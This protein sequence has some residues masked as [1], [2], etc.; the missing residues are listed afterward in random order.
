MTESAGGVGGR[1]A[2]GIGPGL[3]GLAFAATWVASA[4]AP[5]EPATFLT[6]YLL[7]GLGVVLGLWLW[8]RAEGSRARRLW[9]A[10]LVTIGAGA[11][12]GGSSH[13]LGAAEEAGWLWTATMVA[14]GLAS[15]LLGLGAVW[16]F[17][18]SP[19][20]RRALGAALVLVLLVYV[21]WVPG[22][23]DFRW[24]VYDYG[25]TL[26]VLLLAAAWLGWRRREPSAPWLAAAIALSFA[27]AAIQQL[28]LSPHPRFNHNDLYHVVQAIGLWL[29]YR[30]GLRLPE[31]TG[32]EG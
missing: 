9:A 17:V 11:A 24:A 28:E 8:R 20:L 7:A 12:I 10:A 15:C 18:R 4:G 32:V 5:A 6:D 26:L 22:H 1:L 19:G 3:V 31:A 21:V 14:I 23:P 2:L 16:A 30:A 27:A 25:L 13:A 29:F